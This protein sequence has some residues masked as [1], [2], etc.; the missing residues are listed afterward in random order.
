MCDSRIGRARGAASAGDIYRFEGRASRALGQ[1]GLVHDLAD[2]LRQF[3]ANIETA[4]TSVEPAPVTGAPVFAMTIVLAVPDEI[5]LPELEAELEGVCDELGVTW[6]L[7]D[8]AAAAASHG[9]DA[10]V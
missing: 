3:G 1:A 2:V 8:T 6:T 9:S 5:A 7:T 4:E 10:D